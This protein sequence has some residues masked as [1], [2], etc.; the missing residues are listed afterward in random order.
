MFHLHW[1]DLNVYGSF[2]NDVIQIWRL[3]D[4]PPRPPSVTLNCLTKVLTPPQLRD[5]IYEQPVLHK[6]Y[7]MIC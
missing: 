7:F 5:V 6:R 4:S 3:S 1:F 2:I